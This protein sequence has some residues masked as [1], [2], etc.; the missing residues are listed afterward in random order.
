MRPACL[1][2][3]LSALA[4]VP[5]AA[6]AQYRRRCRADDRECVRIYVREESDRDYRSHWRRRQLSLMVGVLN[7]DLGDNDNLPMAA[8]RADRRVSRLVRAELD[9]T[10]AFGEL[11]GVALNPPGG[12]VNTSLATATV[13]VQGEL[14]IPYVRP[15]AGAALGLFGRFDEKGKGG[16]RFV[17]TTTAFPIGVR[18]PVGDRLSLRAEVRFRFDADPTGATTQ[19]A[20]QTAGLSFA[21]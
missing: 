8:L 19:E 14:P 20:E 5:S 1:L 13:G 17:R 4:L 7:T 15:Y 2:A 6:D 10:Y 3:A 11:E 16:E 12:D 21:F 9:V 18:I